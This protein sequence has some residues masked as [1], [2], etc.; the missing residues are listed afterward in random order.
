LWILEQAC[1]RAVAWQKSGPPVKVAVN[2]SP[3]Q[4]F[5]DDFVP[6]VKEV[7]ARAGLAPAL[8]QIELTESVMLTSRE[9]TV[10]K[11]HELRAM[12]VSLAVDDFGSGYSA[13]SYLGRL[14]FTS[15]KIGR[16]FV[17]DLED[18]HSGRMIETLVALAH[19]FDMSVV[20]EGV[21]T[22]AQM[23]AIRTFGCDEVQGF[24]LGRPTPAPEC[25][26]EQTAIRNLAASGDLAHLSSVL[27]EAAAGPVVSPKMPAAQ[28]STPP[29]NPLRPTPPASNG[30]SPI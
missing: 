3:V 2:V 6:N 23:A 13:L 19:N 12:G 5:R 8:L 27:T 9:Q 22:D 16:P 15:L 1:V 20:V 29:D 25:F 11:M 26:L 7:L 24:L 17:Q 28:T 18:P 10:K 4:F 30:S 21:E 14:P